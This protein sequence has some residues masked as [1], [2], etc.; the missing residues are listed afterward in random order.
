MFM[1]PD[2]LLS[3]FFHPVLDGELYVQEGIISRDQLES[4]R[5]RQRKQKDETGAELPV[6]YYMLQ[7]GWATNDDLLKITFLKK[8]LSLFPELSVKSP[9]PRKNFIS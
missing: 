8:S 1:K 7:S 3:R 2:R 4:I 6:D 5:K 9:S